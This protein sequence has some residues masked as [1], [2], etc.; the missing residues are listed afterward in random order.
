MTMLA[1][2]VLR[3]VEDRVMRLV[4][5]RPERKNALTHAM[6]AALA[7]G[8]QA[9]ATDAG[10]RAVLITG[11]GDSFTAGNDMGD[12]AA[13]MPA[14]ELPVTRFLAA[15]RDLDKPVVAAVNGLAIGVGLT[16]LL[17]CDLALAA[18][19][20][21]FR[22]PFAQLG[23]V[24]EAASS[25]LLPMTVGMAWANEILLAGRTLT[26]AEAASI[27]LVSRVMLAADLPAAAAALV[28]ELADLAPGAVQGTKR[29]VRRHR[30][31]VIEQMA[32]ESALFGHQ[33]QSAEFREAATAFMQRRKPVFA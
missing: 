11:A 4:I 9:A 33:L 12:F 2:P 31:L 27:G 24:P 32:A 25:L 8:L 1:E 16:M 23:L 30:Q 3:T 29:L 22:A 14:G 26:A 13:G 7:D 20:A 5:N 6:H 28:Q 21:S 18:D 19:T 17:H 15:L 10:V